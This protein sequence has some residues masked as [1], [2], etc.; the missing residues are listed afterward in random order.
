M[1]PRSSNT[2]RNLHSSDKSRLPGHHNQLKP[3]NTN[4]QL[5]KSK[6]S[7]PPLSE[8]PTGINKA[9]GQLSRQKH[10]YRND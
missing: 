10:E 5:G 4:N 9:K 2:L 7:L 1:F 3:V 6:K 8:E